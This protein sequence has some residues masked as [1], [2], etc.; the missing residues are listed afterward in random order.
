MGGLTREGLA[1][2]DSR[3]R[4]QNPWH[5]SFVTEALAVSGSMLYAGYEGLAAINVHTGRVAWSRR[6]NPVTG[7]TPSGSIDALATDG[8]TA[9]VGGYFVTIGGQS[10]QSLAAI[11]ARSGRIT[12]WRPLVAGSLLGGLG[13]VRALAVVGKTLYVGGEFDSVGGKPRVNLAAFDT[14][15]GDLL[16]W[17]PRAESG[18]SG[19][20][21]LSASGNTLYVGGDFTKVGGEP[22]RGAAAVDLRTGAVRPWNPRLGGTPDVEVDAI[23]VSNSIVYIG[24]V[25]GSVRSQ[26]RRNLAG[27][28]V[29]SAVPLLWSPRVG[30]LTSDFGVR[31]LAVGPSALFVGGGFESVD[32]FEQRYLAALPLAG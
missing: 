2:I 3:T 22:R 28:R 19:V 25:F 29:S 5:P 24:G 27:V 30:E 7:D 23:A 9:Y 13:E 8:A 20:T 10:R 26:P 6:V 21:A 16:P 14:N 15:T 32:G 12:S 18:I 11:D 31:A 17:N 4:R 1:A